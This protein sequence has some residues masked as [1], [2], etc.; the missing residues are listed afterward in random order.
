LRIDIGI[1]TRTGEVM[2]NE[3]GG[4]NS[5]AACIEEAGL[6]ALHSIGNF[7]FP[8]PL[9]SKVKLGVHRTRSQ[10]RAYYLIGMN[11]GAGK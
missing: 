8:K 10:K 6:N 7:G 3:Q 11:N 4:M 5:Q 2:T 9:K 1:D